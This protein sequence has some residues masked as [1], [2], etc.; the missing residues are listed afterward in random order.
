MFEQAT[1]ANGPAGKRV[2]TTVLG[3]TSQVALVGFA[4]LAPMVWPQV[5][6]LAKLEIN[7]AP[8]LPPGPRHLGEERPK[9]PA[10][11]TVVRTPF[12]SLLDYQP[13]RVPDHVAMLDEE[14]ARAFVAG[15]LPGNGSG[16]PDGVPGA[17]WRDL[18]INAPRVP[19]P[20]IEE[21]AAATP[22]PTAPVEVPRYRVGGLVQLGRTLHKGEAVYPPIA[23]AA[24]ASGNV[25]LECVVGTDGHVHEVKVKS[26]N[27]LL[28][29]AAVEAAWQ[30]VYAPSQLNGVPIE[31]VTILTFS[32]KLN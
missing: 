2:W 5:L 12:R 23:R 24:H 16:V 19:P 1:I 28:V 20:H 13:P 14:P 26:G 25:E 32:F 3:M 4:V 7:L 29:R 22:A 11:T 17:F 6:P 9:Q 30:W 21:K 10:R 31:I 27:P 18:P 8:P 15:S